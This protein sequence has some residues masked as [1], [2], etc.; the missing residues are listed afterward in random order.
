MLADYGT[1]I[2]HVTLIK[3]NEKNEKEKMYDKQTLCTA[4]RKAMSEKK[5]HE[6]SPSPNRMSISP[7]PRGFT[8]VSERLEGFLMPCNLVT[9]LV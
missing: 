6:R 7:Q 8:E 9:Y 5:K 4:F 2:M 1:L 3:R